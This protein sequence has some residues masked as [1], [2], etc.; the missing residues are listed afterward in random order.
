MSLKGRYIIHPKDASDGK[1]LVI[2]PAPPIYPPP[3]VPLIVIN[4]MIAN[5][6]LVPV[7]STT[8]KVFSAMVKA[9]KWINKRDTLV[10][11]A[12]TGPGDFRFEKVNEVLYT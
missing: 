3:D 1:S 7:E 10:A 4:N 6:N 12:T 9:Y 5:W 11:S 8:Y 2:G